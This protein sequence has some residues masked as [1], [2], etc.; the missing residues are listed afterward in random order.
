MTTT[1]PCLHVV[2]ASSTV[3]E[4]CNKLVPAAALHAARLRHMHGCAESSLPTFVDQ[5]VSTHTVVKGDVVGEV[6]IWVRPRRKLGSQGELSP[7]P[8]DADH[9]TTDLVAEIT[10]GCDAVGLPTGLV[11]EVK[12]QGV[13]VASTVKQ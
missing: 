11:V 4:R 3:C 13:V 7:D 2:A 8:P 9:L 1:P 5:G 6:V 12:A 10:T